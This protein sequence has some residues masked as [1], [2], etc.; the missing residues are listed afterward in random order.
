MRDESFA[1]RI[2]FRKLDMFPKVS[3]SDGNS[4]ILLT[5]QDGEIET[6]AWNYYLGLL[7]RNLQEEVIKYRR[8][9]DRQNTLF[10]K[11]LVFIAYYMVFDDK[12]DFSNYE[13]NFFGKPF[14]NISDFEFSIS[15]SGNMVVCVF[16]REQIGID[17]EEIKTINI[18]DFI[19]VFTNA[20]LNKIED[21]GPLA[22]YELWTAK[23]AVSKA[24]GRGLSLGMSNI[25]V[26]D[27]YTIYDNM[28]W[29]N[30][31]IVYDGY[32]FT[33]ASQIDNQKSKIIEVKF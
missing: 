5:R 14:I 10:G 4:F 6:D 20:E 29:F 21:V 27:D 11:L 8:W 32:Y 17:V 18:D 13:K 16:S 15:H 31:K 12:L 19:S 22:F 1:S 7:P 23:E 9:Q 2:S 25:E 28:R 26:G 33:K 24:I 30:E 3:I